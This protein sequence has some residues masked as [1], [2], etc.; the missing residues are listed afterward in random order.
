[1]SS[2]R[3]GK[4]IRISLSPFAGL[5]LPCESID[6]NKEFMSKNDIIEYL[7]IKLTTVERKFRMIKNYL[8]D[9]VYD[10]IMDLEN[11]LELTKEKE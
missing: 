5:G 4:L 11:Y 1:M 6:Y 10:A 9:D 8:E 3:V 2:Y 7:E